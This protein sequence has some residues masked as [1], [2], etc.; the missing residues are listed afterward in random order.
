MHICAHTGHWNQ[1]TKQCIDQ[2]MI[3]TV[4]VLEFKLITDDLIIP[5]ASNLTA[6]LIRLLRLQLTISGNALGDQFAFSDLVS[7]GPLELVWYS[8]QLLHLDSRARNYGNG[9]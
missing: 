6:E 2:W 9:F 3:N 4:R 1:K 7:K 8:P 5:H